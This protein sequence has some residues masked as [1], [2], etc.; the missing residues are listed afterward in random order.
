MWGELLKVERDSLIAGQ[1][2]KT[3]RDMLNDL[4]DRPDFGVEHLVWYL[5]KQLLSDHVDDL[6]KR[7]IVERYMSRFYKEHEDR[8]ISLRDPLGKVRRDIKRIPDQTPAA[9]A[10]IDQLLKDG[11]VERC[12]DGNGYKTTEKGNRL[13]V[14]SL[15][16]RMNRAKAEKLLK[17]V[18]ERIA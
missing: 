5:H 12:E 17:G 8:V 7:G 16:P 2:I 15:V 14:T 9:R 18:R 13:A 1:K 11:M 4:A 10:L 6:V 3:V